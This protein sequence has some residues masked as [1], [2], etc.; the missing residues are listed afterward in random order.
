MKALSLTQPWAQLV[1][2]GEKHV[3]TRSWNTK[4]RG[5]I[6][7]HASKKFPRPARDLSITDPLYILALGL[8]GVDGMPLGAIIGTVEI[9]DVCRTDDAQGISAKEAAFGDYGSGRWAW[10]LANEVQFF[11]PIPCRG[12]LGFWEIPE[13]IAAMLIP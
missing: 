4:L 1:V 10:S 6:A 3:E 11:D 2:M 12:A 7:I 5:R 13:D 9:T 8:D